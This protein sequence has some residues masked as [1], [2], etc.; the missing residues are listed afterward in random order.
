MRFDVTELLREK[1]LLFWLAKV[2][3][4]FCI[5]DLKSQCALMER[6]LSQILL[7]YY[8]IKHY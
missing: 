7:D 5:L 1:R 2:E 4:V 6:S 3:T 8:I